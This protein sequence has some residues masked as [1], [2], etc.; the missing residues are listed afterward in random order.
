MRR[1]ILPMTLA[2]AMSLGLLGCPSSKNLVANGEAVDTSQLSPELQSDYLVFSQRCSRCH[3]LSRALNSGDRDDIF[4]QRYVTRMR[5]QPAS[6]IAPE[7]EPPILRF[8]HHYSA[9]LRAERGGQK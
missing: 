4:W 1:M 7:D 2:A 3:A 8:L 9:S 5:R 6:G